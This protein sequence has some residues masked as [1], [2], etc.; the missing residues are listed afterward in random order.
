[1][2]FVLMTDGLSA[3]WFRAL[4]AE[5]CVI[6]V[7]VGMFESLFYNVIR[8]HTYL[9]YKSSSQFEKK[10]ALLRKAA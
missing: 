7:K 9:N 8:L 1:M 2:K 6:G 3:N 4:L 10:K 5:K